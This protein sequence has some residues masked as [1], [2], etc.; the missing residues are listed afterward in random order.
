MRFDIK[1]KVKVICRERDKFSSKVTSYI[2]DGDFDCK[3][4]PP[5]GLRSRFNPELEYFAVL[6]EALTEEQ[7][8]IILQLIRDFGEC[9]VAV[10]I[11]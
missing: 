2:L 6:P 8:P 9:S 7:T 3:N 5:L 1:A 11:R 10:K 4:L